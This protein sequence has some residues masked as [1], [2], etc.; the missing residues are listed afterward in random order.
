MR[1]LTLKDKTHIWCYMLKT[2][3]H[4]V[5]IEHDLLCTHATTF[6]PE[7]MEYGGEEEAVTTNSTHVNTS[8]RLDIDQHFTADDGGH[9]TNNVTSKGVWYGGDDNDTC[10][11]MKGHVWNDESG[12]DGMTE[13]IVTPSFVSE[14]GNV[15]VWPPLNTN[16][17][18]HH[19]T[20]DN[21]SS[22]GRDDGN[23]SNITMKRER[24]F[25]KTNDT[26]KLT[27][28][29]NILNQSLKYIRENISRTE[30]NMS[31]YNTVY[32]KGNYSY[33]TI[34][35]LTIICTSFIGSAIVIA[36]GLC[37]WWRG[38]TWW[39]SQTVYTGSY[40]NIIYMLLFMVYDL[41]R[42]QVWSVN[43]FE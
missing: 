18:T 6:I 5:T 2:I 43:I 9:S 38:S 15:R 11:V 29:D 36:L 30:A 4:I 33:K 14:S 21:V 34:I 31:D 28:P 12:M 42:N 41:K 16:R 25:L 32:D 26:I 27:S 35:K 39:R 10:I 13:T 3:P 40:V 37:L 8:T 19:T 1:K 20:I 24:W 7:L 17:Q 23:G 22:I